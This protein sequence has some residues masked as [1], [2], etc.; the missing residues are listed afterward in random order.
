MGVGYGFTGNSFAI[1][2]KDHDIQSLPLKDIETYVE[3]FIQAAKYHSDKTFAVTRVG[4]GLAG[5]KDKEI[6]PMFKDA[7]SNCH[8]DNAWKPLLGEDRTYWGTF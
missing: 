6:A 7:P 2:T 5:Y 4:C 8:F 3:L 1:P